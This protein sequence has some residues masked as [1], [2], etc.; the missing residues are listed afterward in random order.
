MIIMHIRGQVVKNGRKRKRNTERKFDNFSKS[1]MI[2]HE[3][4]NDIKN[5]KIQ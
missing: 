3:A 2:L 1:D 5:K 4:K